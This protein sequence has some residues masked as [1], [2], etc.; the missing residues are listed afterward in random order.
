MIKLIQTNRKRDVMTMKTG[1]V[2]AKLRLPKDPNA[3]IKEYLTEYIGMSNVDFSVLISGP[4][5]CGK[6]T[7]V[8]KWMEETKKQKD[9]KRVLVSI[10][11]AATIEEIKH[12]V[13]EQAHPTAAKVVSVA[14]CASSVVSS[15]VG[16]A[17]LTRGKKEV[18]LEAN[19][20]KLE[21]I[22][23]KRLNLHYDV[24]VFDDVERAVV[25]I[26]ELFGYFSGLLSDGTKVILIGDEKVLRKR[27]GGW[28]EA[29]AG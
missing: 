20:D 10:N 2:E 4:W 17:G 15:L 23:P 22:V 24:L 25:R 26:E 13:F 8:S 18:S 14:N 29:E 27:W 7:L 16:T 9:K 6:T 1:K 21:K 3:F 28:F 5:G 12:R 11:G 19:F